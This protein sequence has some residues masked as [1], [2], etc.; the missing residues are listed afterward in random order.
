MVVYIKEAHPS[1]GWRSR[2]T[3]REGIKIKQPTTLA[4]RFGVAKQCAAALKL[5]MPITVDQVDGKTVNKDYAGWPERLTLVD[6]GGKVL[7]YGDRGPRGFAPNELESAIKKCMARHAAA[8]RSDL[9]GAL[10]EAL[11]Q[12]KK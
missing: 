5:S 1:D 11:N 10:D 9:D 3:D 8:M 7:Y 2:G 12:S 4:E 6:K